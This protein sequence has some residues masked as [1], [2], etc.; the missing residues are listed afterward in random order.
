[1]VLST[2]YIDYLHKVADLALERVWGQRHCPG[3]GTELTV[4]ELV[5]SELSFLRQTPGT[6]SLNNLRWFS[7]TLVRDLVLCVLL[8]SSPSPWNSP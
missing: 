1:M 4:C 8:S 7:S 3:R 2:L 6:W 5:A